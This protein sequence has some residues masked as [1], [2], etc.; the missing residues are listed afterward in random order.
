LKNT[1]RISLDPSARPAVNMPIGAPP[2]GC[3]CRTRCPRADP[4][5]AAAVPPLRAIGDGPF[6]ACRHLLT[7][8]DVPDAAS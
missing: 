7:A 5:C 2:S 8:E 1:Q 4:R 6:A 3:R